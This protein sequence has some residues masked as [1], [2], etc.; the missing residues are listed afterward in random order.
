MNERSDVIITLDIFEQAALMHSNTVSE[1]AMKLFD[2]LM[3]YEVDLADVESDENVRNILQLL[4]AKLEDMSKKNRTSKLWIQY[5][6]MLEILRTFIKAERTENRMLHLQTV[7]D[8]LPYFAATGHNAYTKS[9][10]I[11]L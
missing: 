11:Y 1:E 10:H 9:G 8:V 2:N 5:V 4:D 3:K 6:K 7:R